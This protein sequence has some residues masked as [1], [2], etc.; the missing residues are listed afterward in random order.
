MNW[1]SIAL[2]MA[3]IIAASDVLIIVVYYF[4]PNLW[5]MKTLAEKFNWDITKFWLE[6]T[7]WSSL[8]MLIATI[9]LFS[10]TLFPEGSLMLSTISAG[11]AI[12]L[13]AHSLK[14]SNFT[15]FADG[16]K[17]LIFALCINIIFGFDWGYLS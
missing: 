17:W 5:N 11:W 4:F 8:A 1:R 13:F 7:F 9:K 6:T 10:D 14:E 16:I 3:V 12:T 2:W 15:K